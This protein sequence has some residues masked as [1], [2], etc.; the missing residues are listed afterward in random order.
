VSEQA[1]EKFGAYW[2]RCAKQQGYSKEPDSVNAGGNSGFQAIHLAALFGAKKIVLIG[3][4]MMRTD[5]KFHWHGKHEGRLPNGTGFPGWIKSMGYLAKDL[6]AMGV[7]VINCT[8][9]TALRCF[10]RMEL[11]DALRGETISEGLRSAPDERGADET[12]PTGVGLEEHEG[13]RGV[14]EVELPGPDQPRQGDS[15][16]P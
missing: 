1:S 3:F 6:Q 7:E 4:D 9:R 8:R 10:P 16:D 2:I 5:G 12:V 13:Q 14:P 11:E 15:A